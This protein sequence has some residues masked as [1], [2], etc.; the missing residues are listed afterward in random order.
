V[1]FR[2]RLAGIALLFALQGFSRADDDDDDDDHNATAIYTCTTIS[3][4]GR[5][6]LANDLT[7]C[8]SGLPS[9]SAMSNS[10]CAAIPYREIYLHLHPP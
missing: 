1:R 5:Y 2:P 10:S 9:R 7:G 8:N 3:L 6:F 4:A